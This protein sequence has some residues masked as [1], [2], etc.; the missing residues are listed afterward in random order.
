MLS[1]AL[2]A[3]LPYSI[4]YTAPFRRCTLLEERTQHAAAMLVSTA[5]CRGY[6]REYCSGTRTASTWS[7][8][9]R[10]PYCDYQY[11]YC[12]Y[13]YPCCDYQYPLSVPLLLR[14]EDHVDLVG[15]VPLLRSA[16]V[17]TWV[18]QVRPDQPC[19]LQRATCNIKPGQQHATYNVQ[20]A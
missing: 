20:R 4:D 11:P 13:Q 3:Q 16:N 1:L 8:V 14:Y 5:P 7:G 18:V 2:Y 9:C 6:T 19:Q 15:R 10:Y 12:D 17:P